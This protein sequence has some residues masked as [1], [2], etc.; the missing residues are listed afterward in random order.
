MICLLKSYSTWPSRVRRNFFLLR[1]M[2]SDLNSRSSELICWLTADW[3]TPL[4]WAALVKLSVSAKSQNTFRLSIC[5]SWI[6]PQIYLFVNN[7]NCGHG[8]PHFGQQFHAREGLPQ[9]RRARLF[10]RRQH[11]AARA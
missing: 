4:I 8:L 6:K 11:V 3:V 2:R 1:S 7:R 5:I 10:V 9:I